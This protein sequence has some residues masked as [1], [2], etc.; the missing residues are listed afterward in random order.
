MCLDITSCSLMP[1][2]QS[3]HPCKDNCVFQYVIQNL[4]RLHINMITA[5]FSFIKD[6]LC[7]DSF[8]QGRPRPLYS[9]LLLISTVICSM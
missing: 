9:L 4:I 8:G 7:A 3:S 6:N 1:Y 5:Q 2:L